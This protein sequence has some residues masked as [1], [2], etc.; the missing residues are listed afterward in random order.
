MC[1]SGQQ[2]IFVEP[3]TEDA[4]QPDPDYQVVWLPHLD[5]S[6]VAHLAKCEVDCLGVARSGKRFGLRVHATNFQRVFTNA[7]PDAVYLAPGCRTTYQC[8]P[9]PFGSDRKAIAKILKAGGWECRPL[10]PLHHVPG[11]LMWAVQAVTEPPLT[12]LAMQHGQVL[13]TRQDTKELPADAEPKI[14]GHAKTV[15]LCRQTDAAGP[16]P[17]LTQ[18]PW[19]KAISLAPAA[20]LAQPA[21]N[22]LH[23]LEHRLEQSILAK[24]P[25]EKMEVDGQ[26]QRL[27][28]LESQVQQLTA[29]QV[30][31]ECTIH[32]HHQQNSAQVQTLQQQM[33]VQLDLQTQHMSS[34]LTDQMSRIEAI[35]AK[36]PRTE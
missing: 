21:P 20:P 7:K 24:L 8:G 18:D 30:A 10:Q 36:K 32:E 11:G 26:D 23:E 1:T 9:W 28:A 15:E 5:F 34:M 6:A 17:W 12:V 4:L 2:G 13:I 14:V 22:V 19:S 27:Q 25:T 16:D 29:K 35:L 33:K 3:K 31:M